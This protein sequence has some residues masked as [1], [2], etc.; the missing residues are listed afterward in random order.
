MEKKHTGSTAYVGRWEVKYGFDG[1][2]MVDNCEALSQ[3]VI[4]Y[5]KTK[6]CEYEEEVE[7]AKL[8]LAEATLRRVQITHKQMERKCVNKTV[9]YVK[10]DNEV[11]VEKCHEKHPAPHTPLTRLLSIPSTSPAARPVARVGRLH[12]CPLTPPSSLYPHGEIEEVVSSQVI[13]PT[14][15]MS[16]LNTRSQHLGQFSWNDQLF[17]SPAVDTISPTA[18][19]YILD[20]FQVLYHDFQVLTFAEDRVGGRDRRGRGGYSASGGCGRA[21]GRGDNSQ[22]I[23]N[24]GQA[25]RDGS[26]FECGEQG[27]W[28][29]DC[30]RD[31]Q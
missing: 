31:K 4:L 6:I 19:K 17:E 5:N 28:A 25:R 30:S 9:A 20:A 21:R 16:G 24:K 2:L 1:K 15:T 29:R 22:P 11:T 26:C 23:V 18:A 14:P 10:E 3:A 12:D 27:H 8:W 7:F 13:S